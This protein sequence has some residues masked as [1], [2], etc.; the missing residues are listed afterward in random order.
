MAGAQAS[1]GYIMSSSPAQL[2][3]EIHAITPK[4]L[5]GTEEH[6]VYA[7]NERTQQLVV[8]I[9]TAPRSARCR[10]FWEILLLDLH[11]GSVHFEK[12]CKVDMIFHC[13]CYH[14]Y[15]IKETCRLLS[16][17]PGCLR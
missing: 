10:G 6:C 7:L 4:N 5:V 8:R 11:T 9:G 12:K 13:V 1:L 17:T 15:V 14:S 2:K 3:S 16:L